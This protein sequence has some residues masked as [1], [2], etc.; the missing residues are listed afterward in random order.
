[1]QNSNQV[2]ADL[3]FIVVLGA[4]NDDSGV[5]SPDARARA[6]AALSEWHSDTAARLVLTGGFGEH[7]NVTTTPHHDFVADYLFQRG[8]PSKAIFATV[9]SR[10]T[11]EDARMSAV[12]LGAEHGSVCIVVVTSDYHTIRARLLFTEALPV[13]A[14]LQIRSAIS[15]AS[16]VVLADRLMHEAEAIRRHFAH[17]KLVEVD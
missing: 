13:G 3:K 17:A 8:L 10:N 4:A 14:P 12:I 11:V 7:F 6:D 1:M 9:G 2:P 16:P 5:L 15:G